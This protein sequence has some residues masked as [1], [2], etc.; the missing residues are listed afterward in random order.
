MTNLVR[1]V[2]RRL[3][4]AVTARLRGTPVQEIYHRALIATVDTEEVAIHGDE[5]TIT[6]HVPEDSA[7]V[8][9]DQYE[10]VLSEKLSERLSPDSVFYDVGSQ[11]GYFIALAL[12]AGVPD[13]RIFGFEMRAF[14]NHVLSKNFSATGVTVTES[15][16]ADGTDPDAITLDEFAA[17]HEPPTVV[18]IDVEGAE[19]QVLN[20]MR[21]LLEGASP[22][23]FVEVHPDHLRSR[24]RSGRDVTRLLREY[25]YDLSCAEHRTERSEWEAV[26][27]AELPD[28]RT[29]LV[30]ARAGR[31]A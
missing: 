29:Y 4:S 5:S 28:D 2:A 25:D 31:D 10:P 19:M 12:A 20:G 18:K 8:G 9:P 21:S 6:I 27:D 11:Y 13:D 3:P 24:D 7:Y 26:S 30:W 1:N 22:E 14:P 16:V 23:I 15:T 17:S